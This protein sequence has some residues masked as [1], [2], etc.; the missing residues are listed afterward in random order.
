MD[1]YDTNYS[2]SSAFSNRKVSV[3]KV[4]VLIGISIFR[5]RDSIIFNLQETIYQWIVEKAQEY[6]MMDLKNMVI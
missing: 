5:K 2:A 1:R 3:S 6:K 4:S